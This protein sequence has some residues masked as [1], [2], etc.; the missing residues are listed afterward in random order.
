MHPLE[1][2]TLDDVLTH[3]AQ[4]IKLH[5]ETRDE[6]PD[7]SSFLEDLLSLS[8]P[9]PLSRTIQTKT[10]NHHFTARRWRGL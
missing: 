5:C 2:F 10:Q 7:T 3:R 1:L 6:D 9:N 4:L 8:E